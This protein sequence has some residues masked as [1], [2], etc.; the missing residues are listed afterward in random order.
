MTGA[1]GV[2]LAATVEDG[3]VF[4][5]VVEEGYGVVS[6][7]VFG[8]KSVL[9]LFSFF[10][11]FLDSVSY[12]SRILPGSLSHFLQF[13]NLLFYLINILRFLKLIISFKPQKLLNI[14]LSMCAEWQ[15]K[16]FIFLLVLRFIITLNIRKRSLQVFL[17][18]NMSKLINLNIYS[19]FLIPQR[20]HLY[21]RTRHLLN[22][23]FQLLR[24]NLL[25]HLPS[26]YYI[27]F[28]ILHFFFYFISLF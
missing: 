7:A 25:P 28:L 18:T 19:C 2:E 13:S 12:Q 20:L 11:F 21:I 8:E 9:L 23:S 26:L 1:S 17:L 14:V 3:N 4:V 16:P 5:S 10:D 6:L 22:Q 27:S 24:I 15:S